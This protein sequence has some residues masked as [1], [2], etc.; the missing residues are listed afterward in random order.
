MLGRSVFWLIWCRHESRLDTKHGPSKHHHLC[1][2]HFRATAWKRQVHWLGPAKDNS[3]VAFSFDHSGKVS[4]FASRIGAS[5]HCAPGQLWSPLSR[6]IFVR[7]QSFLHTAS[8]GCGTQSE[9]GSRI[10]IADQQSW[11]EHGQPLEA[12]HYVG[13]SYSCC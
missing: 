6:C 1:H 5:R 8:K 11:P 9:L 7:T 12:C 2:A 10:F 3:I 4:S 13:K